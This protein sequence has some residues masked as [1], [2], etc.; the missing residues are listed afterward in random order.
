MKVEKSIEIY[1]NNEIFSNINEDG[2]FTGN[3][4]NKY[5]KL[6]STKNIENKVINRAIIHMIPTHDTTSEEGNLYGYC[7]ALFFKIVV[8]NTDTMEYYSLNNRDAV[9]IEVPTETRIFKDL[10]TMIIC[11]KPCKIDFG[12]AVFVYKA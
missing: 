11:R 4:D 5:T 2:I 12:Q 6:D 1:D 3:S 10:S 8:Y 9:N 7:D